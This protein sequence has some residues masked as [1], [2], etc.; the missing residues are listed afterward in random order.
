MDVESRIDRIEAALNEINLT[1][2]TELFPIDETYQLKE[3]HMFLEEQSKSEF[4]SMDA[5]PLA[6]N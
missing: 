4:K 5:D 1:R 3:K 2:V 6:E